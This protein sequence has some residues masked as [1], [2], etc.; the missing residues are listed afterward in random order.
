[1]LSDKE[2][3]PRIMFSPQY[4]DAAHGC[5]IHTMLSK[6]SPALLGGG[7]D[8]SQPVCNSAAGV[9]PQADHRGASSRPLK[10]EN[11]SGAFSSEQ[12]RSKCEPPPMCLQL[13]FRIHLAL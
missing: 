7:F 10:V 5:K 8:F 4:T 9:F 13:F 3:E 1:M 12:P 6:A 11:N 2:H